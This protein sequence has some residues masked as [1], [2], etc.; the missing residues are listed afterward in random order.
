MVTG[1]SPS[2]ARRVGLFLWYTRAMNKK[3]TTA[4]Y[5]LIEILVS[6]FIIGIFFILLQV[7]AN[8]TLLN[9]AVRNREVALRIANTE[10]ENLRAL[11]YGSLPESGSFSSPLLN[12]LSK[13]AAN[14]AVSD[15][16]SQTKQ[17]VATVSWKEPGIVNTSTVSLTTLITK[18]GL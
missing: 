3:Q 18:G 6:I 13:G 14:R 2:F 8:T 7:A 15:F 10:I 12:S 17:L 5:T 11:P 9:R 1:L 4:G 16:N